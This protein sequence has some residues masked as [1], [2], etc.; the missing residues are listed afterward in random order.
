MWTYPFGDVVEAV[1]VVRP[2]A[3]FVLQERQAAPP[4]LPGLPQHLA[5]AVNQSLAPLKAVGAQRAVKQFYL[6]KASH[7]S[8]QGH[9]RAFTS[10][11]QV[12]KKR[13]KVL[14]KCHMAAYA[15]HGTN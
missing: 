4:P 10:F 8:T 14:Y 2:E 6:L 9:L 13:K 12:K 7:P 11:I 5:D 15:A 3:G 1:A